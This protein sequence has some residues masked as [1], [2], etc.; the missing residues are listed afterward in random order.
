M[1]GVDLN[2]CVLLLSTHLSD[3][4]EIKFSSLTLP[5]DSIRSFLKSLEKK[6]IDTKFI[7][8][9]TEF[10]L[11]VKRPALA[12]EV[13]IDID[14]YLG[15]THYHLKVKS[16]DTSEAIESLKDFFS[17]LLASTKL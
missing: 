13:T 8:A 15:E 3:A 11:H 16:K 7:F 10:V 17:I 1:H 2:E 5:S 6:E 9:G 4:H 14:R 12:V